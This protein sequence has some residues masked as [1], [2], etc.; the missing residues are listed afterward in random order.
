MGELHVS[1]RL[2][3]ALEISFIASCRI[4]LAIDCDMISHET[5]AECLKADISIQTD[6]TCFNTF[7]EQNNL[8]IQFSLNLPFS[9]VRFRDPCQVMTDLLAVDVIAVGYRDFVSAALFFYCGQYY[10]FLRPQ[11]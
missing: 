5:F 4:R 2:V 7:L 11:T 1:D 6:T 8:A 10:S 9:Q 3:D